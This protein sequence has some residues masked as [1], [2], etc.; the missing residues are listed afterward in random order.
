MDR[1]GRRGEGLEDVVT[2]VA[3]AANAESESRGNKR[4]SSER[5]PSPQNRP[6]SS[7][8]RVSGSCFGGR[9][10]GLGFV[11]RTAPSRNPNPEL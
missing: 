8:K 1:L 4:K 3:A 11:T 10:L 6:K 2:P 5:P 7:S 9:F